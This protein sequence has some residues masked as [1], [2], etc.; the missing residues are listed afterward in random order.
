M[1]A[2]K[3]NMLICFL[4]VPFFRNAEMSSE[5]T[6]AIAEREIDVQKSRVKSPTKANPDHHKGDYESI[7]KKMICTDK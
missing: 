3:A 1:T 6:I 2:N 5:N 7:I 4:S